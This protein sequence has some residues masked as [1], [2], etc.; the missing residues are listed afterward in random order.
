M[1]GF[2]LRFDNGLL[3]LEYIETLFCDR[4]IKILFMLKG[5]MEEEEEKFVNDNSFTSIICWKTTRLLPWR[6]VENT[7]WL[8]S[9]TRICKILQG[10]TL[11]TT[12][13]FKPGF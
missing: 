10:F 5:L 4:E 2:V 11:I 3:L 6:S 7:T 12:S 13:F 9:E 8:I 1:K